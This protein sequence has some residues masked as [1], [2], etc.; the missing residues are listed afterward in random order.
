[1]FVHNVRLLSRE[2]RDCLNFKSSNTL[3]FC[4]LKFSHA[5]NS[6]IL[7]QTLDFMDSLYLVFEFG[8]KCFINCTITQHHPIGDV[9]WKYK[10][11]FIES[12]CYKNGEFKNLSLHNLRMQGVF[13]KY[14]Q[15]ANKPN[16]ED[17][18]SCIETPTD[19]GKYKFRLLYSDRI[20]SSDFISYKNPVIGSLQLI[21]N[22]KINYKFKTTNRTEINEMFEKRGVA[23][24][25]LIVK[26]GLITDTSYCNVLFFDGNQWLTPE[27]PLLEGVRRKFL[28]EKQKIKTANISVNDLNKYEKL[29]LINAM[30][31]FDEGPE[32][33][34]KSILF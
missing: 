29:K 11:K 25:I 21:E 4:G 7:N 17:Y 27:K 15:N 34:I 14:F 33:L 19:D 12:I 10:M 2:K 18:I 28:L 32:I 31:D 24:D 3:V 13:E 22:N 20:I 1:M 9:N 30:L 23:D 26:N 5:S 8:M 16:L 6:N